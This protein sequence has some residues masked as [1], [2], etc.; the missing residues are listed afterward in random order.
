MK[1]GRINVISA[2]SYFIP[3]RR[4]LRSG[5]VVVDEETE[6]EEKGGGEEGEEEESVSM[7]RGRR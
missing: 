2:R 3:V 7:R 4:Q 1:L 6:R 5:A